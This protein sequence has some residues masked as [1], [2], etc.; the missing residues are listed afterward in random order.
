MYSSPYL[1]DISLYYYKNNFQS[2][3]PT[4]LYINLQTLLQ[5]VRGEI[6]IHVTSAGGS[7]SRE[8]G[9]VGPAAT[10][11]EGFHALPLAAVL[12]P[13]VVADRVG[14]G[15]VA[16]AVGHGAD[17]AVARVVRGEVAA[18]VRRAGQRRRTQRALQAPP[19]SPT[20]RRLCQRAPRPGICNADT[21]GQ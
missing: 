1:N 19:H 14:V 10:P 11:L 8:G 20:Y 9:S 7:R 5:N 15:E 21:L 13:H 6:M 18:R 16:R 2:I 12:Y 3:Y 4:A 17:G